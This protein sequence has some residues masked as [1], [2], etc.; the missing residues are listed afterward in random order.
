MALYI[1]KGLEE[2][3]LNYLLIFSNPKNLPLKDDVDLMLIADGR[4]ELIVV[5]PVV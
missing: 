2:G 5:I 3:R 1:T 4:E